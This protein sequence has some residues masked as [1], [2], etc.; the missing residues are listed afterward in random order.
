M[1]IEELRTDLDNIIS[2]LTSSGFENI[3]SK[4]LE[5]INS[6]IPAAGEAGMREAKHLLE[7]LSVSIKA[8]QEGKSPIESGTVRLTALDFYRKNLPNSENIE[9]L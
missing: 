4:I 3:D 7:N 2:G 8:I 1:T 9:D 6:L 5:K